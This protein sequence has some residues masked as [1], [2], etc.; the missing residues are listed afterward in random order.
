M[1]I[2]DYYGY[3]KCTEIYK[4]Q[5]SPSTKYIT[6]AIPEK[7]NLLIYLKVKEK[8]AG[9]IIVTQSEKR[10]MNQKY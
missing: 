3:F 5:K 6:A 9:N 8:S 10:F 4:F 2:D 1:E 7:E